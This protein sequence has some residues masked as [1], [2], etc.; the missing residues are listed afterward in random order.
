MNEHVFAEEHPAK[1]LLE[2][3]GAACLAWRQPH[4]GSSVSLP[5]VLLL[6]ISAR[7][8]TVYMALLSWSAKVQK[9][10]KTSVACTQTHLPFSLVVCLE[11]D[12]LLF[13]ALGPRLVGR[14]FKKRIMIR[15]EAQLPNSSIT[16]ILIVPLIVEYSSI[17]HSFSHESGT[18]CPF[19]KSVSQGTKEQEVLLLAEKQMV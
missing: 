9:K 11:A 17:F 10:P 13:G 3:R 19:Y 6:F 12:G 2:S 4:P 16:S 18:K 7:Q 15:S 8:S 1:L 5:D 14:N